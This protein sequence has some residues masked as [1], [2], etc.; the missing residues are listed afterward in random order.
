MLRPLWG[1]ALLLP[2]VTFGQVPIDPGPDLYAQEAEPKPPPVEHHYV[3]ANITGPSQ[4][5]AG[6][7]VVLDSSGSHAA[8]ARKWDL[9]CAVGNDGRIIPKKSFLT[10][11]NDTKLVF[12]SGTQGHYTFYLVVAGLDDKKEVDLATTTFT[13]HVGPAI[14]PEPVPPDP[15]PPDPTP[16]PPTPIPTEGPKLLVVYE[17]DDLD[18]YP[19]GIVDILTSGAVRQRLKDLK[20]DYRFYD[21]D[22]NM[23]N[24]PKVW[25]D[26]MKLPRAKLPWVIISD[27]KTGESKELP[28]TVDEFQAL[29]DKYLK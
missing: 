6:D 22:T 20:V 25:Q 3:N 15:V 2:L 13:V 23:A 29:I 10:V 24:A 14:P 11:E 7:L 9:V 4:V 21:D 8:V 26:A 27:G 28:A 16:V 12:A 17:V 5:D 1:L 19:K 18:D